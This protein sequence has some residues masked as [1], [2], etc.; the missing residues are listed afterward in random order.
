MAEWSKAAVLKTVERKLRGFESY[1]LRHFFTDFRTPCQRG[2]LQPFRAFTKHGRRDDREADGARLL[3][4]CGVK[5]TEGSNPSLSATFCLPSS[6]DFDHFVSDTRG[7]RSG[8]DLCRDAGRGLTFF[9]PETPCH[10]M[11]IAEDMWDD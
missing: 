8:Q 1:F 10:G 6:P 5:A 3:S 11:K 2:A 7:R 4:E 9:H